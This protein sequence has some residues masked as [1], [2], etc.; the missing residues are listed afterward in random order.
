[1]DLQK[2][3]Y[4]FITYNNTL[5]YLIPYMKHTVYPLYKKTHHIGLP[6]QHLRS[7]AQVVFYYQRRTLNLSAFFKL[8][9]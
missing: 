9:F 3:V 8:Y 4:G 5:K 7:P 2:T 6:P 1:M